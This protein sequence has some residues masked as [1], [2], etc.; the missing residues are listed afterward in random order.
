MVKPPTIIADAT[1]KALAQHTELDAG[2]NNIS[3]TSVI[4]GRV[5]VDMSDDDIAAL[6]KGMA[7]EI[8]RLRRLVIAHE[9][10]R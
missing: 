6:I 5:A 10:H 3:L 7:K 2:Y 1:L 8:L 4:A 9:G